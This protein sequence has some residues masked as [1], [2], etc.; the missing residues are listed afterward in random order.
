M[1]DSTT[2]LGGVMYVGAGNILNIL[3]VNISNISSKSGGAIYGCGLN[4]SI[5]GSHFTNLSCTNGYG[6]AIF[7]GAN[8][9]FSLN[10]VYIL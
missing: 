2:T 4:A 10:G 7:F 1:V 6:G 8:S 5:N 9:G 3:S